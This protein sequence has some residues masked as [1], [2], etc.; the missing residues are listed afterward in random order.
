MI[1]RRLE[2]P[3]LLG[4]SM[5]TAALSFGNFHHPLRT[6]V[7]LIF[8]AFVPGLAF[9]RLAKLTDPVMTVLLAVPVSFVASTRPY[10]PSSCMPGSRPGTWGCRS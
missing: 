1:V 2:S 6:A 7:A 4:W 8:L 3:L 5:L 9:L 10:R